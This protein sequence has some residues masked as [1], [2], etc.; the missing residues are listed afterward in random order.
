MYIDSTS[1]EEDNNYVNVVKSAAGATKNILAFDDAVLEMDNDSDSGD[2]HEEQNTNSV[3]EDL[4]SRSSSTDLNNFLE[5]K[6]VKCYFYYK[7]DCNKILFQLLS[8]AEVRSVEV[9][10]GR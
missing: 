2:E 1:S 9:G 7:S 6:Q 5:I 4:Q 8:R 10:R 3:D